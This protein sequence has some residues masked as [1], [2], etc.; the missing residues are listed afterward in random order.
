MTAG[1][2][3]RGLPGQDRPRVLVV[4]HED[5]CPLDR[6]GTWLGEAGVQVELC[7]PYAGDRVPDSVAQDGLIVLGGHMGA[8]DDD[9]APWLPATRRLLAR[10]AAAATPTL[11]ICLGAQLLAVACGGLVEVGRAGIEAGVVDVGWRDEA[12]DDL[13]FGDEASARPSMHLDAVVR[14]P[15]GAAWLGATAQYPHQAFRV[16][17]RAW[18]V[19]FHPEVSL[20]IFTAWVEGHDAHWP[21]GGSDGTAVIA[22]LARRDEEVARAGRRL[23]R[24]FALV[25]EQ[26]LSSGACAA[27][28]GPGMQERLPS[29]ASARYRPVR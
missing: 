27:G 24:R 6:L 9:L 17:G 1:G 29:P 22:Q 21:A 8:Y 2:G 13:L 26:G 28:L 16:G 20:P 15:R 3:I 19:Q 14:L 5:V 7:R 23:E 12:V 18:G 11:G 10:A 25:L 4:Q